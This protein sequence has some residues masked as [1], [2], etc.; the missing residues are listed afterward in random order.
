MSQSLNDLILLPALLSA[1]LDMLE[2]RDYEGFYGEAY[3]G[4]DYQ[5]NGTFVVEQSWNHF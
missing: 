3:L 4:R 5:K 1:N 2:S